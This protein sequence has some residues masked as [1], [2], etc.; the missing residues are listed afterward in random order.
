MSFRGQLS[1]LASVLARSDARGG[2]VREL[3][4]EAGEV[5]GQQR[6]QRLGVQPASGARVV[7]RVLTL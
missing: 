4:L 1:C 2:N 6:P 5:G 3:H 7:Q